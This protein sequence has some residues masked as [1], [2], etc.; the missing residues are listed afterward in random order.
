MKLITAL[1]ASALVSLASFTAALPSGRPAMGLFAFAAAALLLLVAVRDYAPRRPL[2]LP[3]HSG[4][5]R[6]AAVRLVAT[7]TMKLAA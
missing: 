1:S 7:E 4:L 3:R 6:P 5:R 2:R